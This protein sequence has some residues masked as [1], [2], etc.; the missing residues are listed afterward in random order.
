[1][2]K[3]ACEV[4]AHPLTHRAPATGRPEGH[5]RTDRSQVCQCLGRPGIIQNLEPA[6][7]KAMQQP[8]QQPMFRV[9]K[10]VHSEVPALLLLLHGQCCIAMAALHLVVRTTHR[11]R[12]WAAARGALPAEC[13]GLHTLC[14][15]PALLRARGASGVSVGVASTTGLLLW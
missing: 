6:L 12:R 11:S 15:L 9:Y 1:M 4:A 7:V 5:G 2:C 10:Q 3:R 13:H 8:M 14:P